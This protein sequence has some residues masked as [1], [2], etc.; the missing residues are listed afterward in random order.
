MAGAES[1]IAEPVVTREIL[2]LARWECE[3]VYLICELIRDGV[4][5]TEDNADRLALA[6]QRLTRV[7][8]ALNDDSVT[9][10]CNGRDKDG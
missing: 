3:T 1:A 6:C 8:D 7:I 5:P 4:L 9:E 2:L 10:L